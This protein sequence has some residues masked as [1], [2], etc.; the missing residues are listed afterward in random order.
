MTVVSE[1]RFFELF[2][3]VHRKLLKRLFPLCRREGLSGPEFLV[4][5]KVNKRG[6]CRA[7]DL[8]EETGI[9]PSTLT[10]ILDRL[11]GRGWIKR[12]PDPDDRRS[13][14]VGGTPRLKSFLADLLAGLEKELQRI[15]GSLPCAGILSRLED[16]L[17]LLLACLDSG[18]G[19]DN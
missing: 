15:F 12:I 14:L 10:G 5:W 7:T 18:K 1:L 13:V 8:A 3:R 6:S 9:P 4:L 11:E 16:D 19:E 17:Q 2:C